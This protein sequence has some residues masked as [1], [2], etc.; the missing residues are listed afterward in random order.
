MIGLTITKHKE[1]EPLP[2]LPS[3]TC[4]KCGDDTLHHFINAKTSRYVVTCH[5]SIKRPFDYCGFHESRF[6]DF[7]TKT[8][9]KK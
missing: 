1:G 5:R 7:K 8:K 2:D 4:P 3:R 9:G 6:I